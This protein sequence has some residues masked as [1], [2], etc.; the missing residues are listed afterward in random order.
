MKR[1]EEVYHYTS[2]EGLLSILV[3]KTLRFTDCQFF[4]DKLEY[5]YIRKP[6]SDAIG[7]IKNKLWN[8]DLI[9]DI[10]DWL[11]E[12]YEVACCSRKMK[13]RYYVFCTSVKADSL[14]MWNYYLKNG[15]YQG[16]N[17]AISL[18][19]MQYYM[20]SLD[21]TDCEFWQGKV[22]YSFSEQAEYLIDY[23]RKIDYEL[24]CCRK[25][26]KTVNDSY[27]ML[28][29]AQEEIIEKIEFCRLFFKSEAFSNEQEYRF[30]LKIPEY[31]NKTEI[32]VQG[33]MI[34]EGV[35]TPYYDLKINEN[36]IEN[37]MISPMLE[38]ELARKGLVIFLNRQQMDNINI[39][40]SRILVRY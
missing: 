19:K 29:D 37:I 3:N 27:A 12:K 23:I 14:N 30:V 18:K 33:F 28:L 11:T 34:K 2:P 10:D 26:A 35:F 21:L 22:M 9:E 6:L 13:M 17:L 36:I 7:K 4:N 31:I 20:E 15:K 8:K 25:E 16:Y 1:I 32:F 5:I 40:E 24:Y 38:K 39:N